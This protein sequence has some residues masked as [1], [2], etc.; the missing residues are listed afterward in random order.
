MDH[1]ISST[2]NLPY[3]LEDPEERQWFGDMLMEYLPN[4]RGITCYP[5]GIRSGQPMTVASY[6]SAMGQDGV[7][8]EE[9]ENKCIGGICGS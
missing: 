1:G 5:D 8:Y 7:V 3:A 9:S 2:I 6:S 4:L